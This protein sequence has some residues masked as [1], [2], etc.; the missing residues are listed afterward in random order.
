MRIQLSD[1]IHADDLFRF[2]ARSGCVVERIAEDQLE[3]SMLGSFRHD[4]LRLELSLLIGAWQTT[5]N[6]AEARILD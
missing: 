2:L 6:G 5:R 3:A 1:G 4:R